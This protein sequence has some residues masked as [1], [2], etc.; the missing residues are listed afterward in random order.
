VFVFWRLLARAFSVAEAR[1]PSDANL[2]ELSGTLS[3][4]AGV[5][6]GEETLDA[7]LEMVVSLAVS[8]IPDVYGASVSLARDGQLVTANATSE[9]VRELDALQYAEDHGPCVDAT[10]TGDRQHAVGDALEERWP[11]FGAAAISAGIATI[12]STPLE[13]PGR[14]IGALNLYARTQ[15]AF[16]GDSAA[17][18]AVFAHH[19]GA[20]LANAAAFAD[21]ESTNRNLLDA[22]A[23]RQLI[24]QAMGII[25]A[26]ER[27]TS[28]EAFDILRRASQQS[29]LK[30]RDIADQF[31][32]STEPGKRTK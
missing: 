6:L 4:L 14:S 7:V 18:A 22:L 28:D 19:A 5:V 29:N 8:A 25:M 2:A 15:D 32:R 10:R 20:V 24:G 27:C 31:V 1:E 13:I 9:L 30:L 12:L 23:T 21:S 26:R 11:V 17:L 16:S 3:A